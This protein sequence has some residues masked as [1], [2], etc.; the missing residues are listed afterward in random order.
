MKKLLILYGFF[1]VSHF[2]FTQNVGIGT[3]TPDASAQ[4]DITHVSKGLLIPRMSTSAITSIGNPAKGLMVYD[5]VKNQLMVNMGT[6]S[7]PNWQTIVANSGWN[8][9]GNSNV[10]TAGVDKGEK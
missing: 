10:N 8:L 3:I 4:L 2:S 7:I 1:F 6:S 5:S 9:T